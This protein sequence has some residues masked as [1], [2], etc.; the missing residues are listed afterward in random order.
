M[1]T[2]INTWILTGI[3]FLLS[4]ASAGYCVMC[5]NS[6]LQKDYILVW[7][8]LAGMGGTSALECAFMLGGIVMLVLGDSCRSL[9][10]MFIN[11]MRLA[12]I[13]LAVICNVG[14]LLIC[15]IFDPASGSDDGEFQIAVIF[16]VAN[17]KTIFSFT[18][19][20]FLSEAF[21]YTMPPPYSPIMVPAE[22][23][24]PESYIPANQQEIEADAEPEKTQKVFVVPR[25][26]FVF[27]KPN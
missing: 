12:E 21:Y 7:G 5:L 26:N 4:G 22:I 23:H 14:F 25:G 18:A 1:R 11:L 19:M 2:T 10:Q 16:L 3:S 8:A 20:V 9:A 6:D 15:F 13:P 27:I 17:I 24:G